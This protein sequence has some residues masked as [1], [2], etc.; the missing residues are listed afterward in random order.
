M[1]KAGKKLGKYRIL[2]RLATG[3]FAEVF[4]ALDSVEGV[5]VALKIPHPQFSSP[6]ILNDFR[7]EVRLTA[8]LEHPN[9]L[10]IKNAEILDGRLIVATPLGKQ[11]LADRMRKRISVALAL[12][13]MEQMLEALA[14][15]H[16]ERIIHCDVKPENL[17]LFP[18][19]WLRLGDFGIAKVAMRT[20]SG[21]GSGTLGYMAPEQAMGKP[22]FRSDVFSAALILYRLLSGELPEWPYRWPLPGHSNLRRKVPPPM[23]DFL[24]RSLAVDQR[25]RFANASQMLSAFQRLL[26]GARRALSGKRRKKAKPVSKEPDWPVIRHREFTRRFRKVLDLRASCGRCNGPMTEAMRGC[27]WCGKSRPKNGAASRFPARCPRCRRG[28]KLDWRFCAWCFGPGFKKVADREYSDVRYEARCDNG[29]CSRK[30][31]M[32]YMRY[33]PWCRRKVRK[34]WPVAGARRRCRSCGWGVV[35]A[36]WDFCPWCVKA[37][38]PQ[39]RRTH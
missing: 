21:S 30:L 4:K 35:S 15:A 38:E 7:K 1:L 39:V 13:F 18:D 34:K 16:H 9:I 2:R 6:Q 27:P 8:G 25:K 37:L 12:D 29:A 20:M 36:Y 32:P 33:C 17:I 22:S 23:V 26:P 28:R 5:N 11:S 31:L 3:G 19:N 14:Y 24:Q 10:P